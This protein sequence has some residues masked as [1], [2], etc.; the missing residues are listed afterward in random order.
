MEPTSC[1]QQSPGYEGTEAPSRPRRWTF[2]GGGGWQLSS[3]MSPRVELCDLRAPTY[4]IHKELLPSCMCC[5]SSKSTGTLQGQNPQVVQANRGRCSA[6][7]HP[8]LVTPGDSVPRIL[9]F[10]ETHRS[11]LPGL[12]PLQPSQPISGTLKVSIKRFGLTARG[13][14]HAHEK[15][16]QF[17]STPT[18]AHPPEHNLHPEPQGTPLQGSSGPA[19]LQE[20]RTHV[21]CGFP[22]TQVIVSRN[23]NSYVEAL[24]P[25][26]TVFG[27]G[28]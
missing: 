9:E 7:I 22:R 28:A 2:P 26:I 21:D 1:P 16:L 24:T 15:L 19:S 27:E 18:M 4:Q 10:P 25:N 3:F 20:H 11:R 17:L 5:C 8:D 13:L 6:F 14:S 23:L 12:R